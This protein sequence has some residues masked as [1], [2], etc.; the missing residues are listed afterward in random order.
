MKKKKKQG[1]AAQSSPNTVWDLQRLLAILLVV[2]GRIGE[3]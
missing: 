2:L 3:G 1:G